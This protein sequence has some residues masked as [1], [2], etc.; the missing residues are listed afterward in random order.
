MVAQ[1]WAGPRGEGPSG[2][3]A[4]VGL[5]LEGEDSEVPPE[6][7]QG[8]WLGRCMNADVSWLR[9]PVAVDQSLASV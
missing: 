1:V 9:G 8:L 3:V 4:A 7:A 2:G 6:V 5:V